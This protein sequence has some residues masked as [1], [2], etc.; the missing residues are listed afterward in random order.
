MDTA[1]LF[2][3]IVIGLAMLGH[4]TQKLFGWFGGYGIAGTGGF[5]E[6]LGFKPGK[7]F[8]AA[9]GLSEAGGGLLVALGLG[10]ALGPAAIVMV[11]L[12]A[13]LTVHVAKGFFAPN[14]F[15]LNALYIAASVGLAYTGGGAF[16]LDNALGF[17]FL[18]G[19]QAASMLL[20][21][22]V[23]LAGLNLLARRAPA[24]QS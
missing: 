9:A 15:E 17:H 20:A 10:G 14:G 1:L 5:F 3:R 23:I 8:A 4:G 11:M 12:V 2:V 7:L 13:A 22:A 6:G 18:D 24:Q 19:T 16:S 21:A